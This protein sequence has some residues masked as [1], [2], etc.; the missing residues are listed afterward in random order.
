M[1]NYS[2]L[3]T[4]IENA[5]DWNN[6]DNEIT[7]QNLLDILET[8]ID[9]LGAKYKF[10]DVATPSSSITTPDEP[11]FYL[12]GA[13]TYTNFSGLSV[14]IPRGTL[15]IFYYDT[16]WHYTTVRTDSDAFFNVNQ[17]LGTPS[18]TYTKADGRNAVPS[19]LRS[20]GM[21]I[22][23][24]TTNGWIIEQNLSTSGTWNADANWQTI[25]PVSVSQNTE[26][27]NLDINIG[28]QT[29]ETA[30]KTTIDNY[31]GR[32][33]GNVILSL[34]SVSLGQFL[35][36]KRDV[37]VGE[38]IYYSFKMG[39][40][41]VAIDLKDSS[42]NRIAYYGK[43]SGG[44]VGEIV[45]GSFTIPS[46]FDHAQL[47]Y[48]S[49]AT[50]LVISV[51]DSKV[52]NNLLQ[53]VRAGAN[54]FSLNNSY[55]N[56][57]DGNVY[58]Q[59]GF[60][61]TPLI[62]INH[63]C[64]IVIKNINSAGGLGYAFYDENG[65]FI[66]GASAVTSATIN[67][68]SIPS[69]AQ[70]VRFSSQS[71]YIN[72]NTIINI[73][74]IESLGIS[75]AEIKSNCKKNEDDITRVNQILGHFEKNF[76]NT[77]VD[78]EQYIYNR[79]MEVV[80]NP[81]LRHATLLVKEGD[82]FRI[83]GRCYG[84]DYPLYILA[85][86]NTLVSY[87]YT[88]AGIYNGIEITIPSGVNKLI[89]NGDAS[90]SGIVTIYAYEIGAF[91]STNAVIVGIGDDFQFNDVNDAVISAGSNG[92]VKIDFGEYN[93][94]VQALNTNKRLIGAD[95]DLCVLYNNSGA[96]DTPPIEIAGGVIKNMTI[97]VDASE[98]S[99]QSPGY[100]LHSDDNACANN[101]LIIENCIFDIKAAAH[102]VGIGLRNGENLIF[103]NCTFIQRSDDSQ[104]AYIHNGGGST[105]T[106]AK[107]SFIGCKFI[108][109]GKCIK[110]QSWAQNC[111]VEY[112]FI[113]N[114]FVSDTYGVSND[115]IFIDNRE[116]S[117]P[118]SEWSSLMYLADTCHGN[119]VSV[120]NS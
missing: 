102:A 58:P 64:D 108:A 48:W 74:N 2:N 18:T 81:D 22:T 42:D 41:A 37:M 75:V 59:N 85:N 5:V 11:L 99:P 76:Y 20:K 16:A 95:R 114:T 96:Y 40:T 92:I 47:T 52:V 23:Y 56:A 26:T 103:R 44:T 94:E 21:I 55:I 10:A 86:N 78:L 116:G 49:P 80:P 89:V 12:A 113:D 93:T 25:G 104:C 62:Y 45:T 57:D 120:L 97:K 61:A 13:G 6:G 19:A 27:H 100:C 105:I 111:A 65:T 60:K 15:A 77:N 24:L 17:Y 51:S 84:S 79:W 118:S 106:P 30:S 110:L 1:A 67:S 32:M 35:F 98:S 112:E 90:G 70:F 50:E 3:K 119:N 34:G 63:L 31:Y 101:T 9:S 69:N 107:I 53:N 88:T 36:S 29:E 14:T 117:T 46:N 83:S 8:I 68:S 87:D 73:G 66:S 33:Y 38:T 91:K 28:E 72:T 115:C 82:K 71:S 7:G 109:K 39:G 43:D 54:I 4:A